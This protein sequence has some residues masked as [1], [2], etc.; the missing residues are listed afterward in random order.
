M[1]LTRVLWSA[2]SKKPTDKGRNRQFKQQ[3]KGG[4][5]NSNIIIRDFIYHFQKLVEQ[6]RATRKQLLECTV[7]QVDLTTRALH[8]FNRSRILSVLSSTHGSFSRIKNGQ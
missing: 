5:D 8:S 1:Q 6:G 4:I 2:Q 7:N 3:V